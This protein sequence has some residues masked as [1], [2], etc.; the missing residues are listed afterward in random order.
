MDRFRRRSYAAIPALF[1]PL[2]SNS[3]RHASTVPPAAVEDWL[4]LWKWPCERQAFHS[5]STRATDDHPQLDFSQPVFRIRISGHFRIMG[6]QET[7][8][9][10]IDSLPPPCA[11]V[12]FLHHPP[13]SRP[14][15]GMV[16]LVPPF[17]VNIDTLRCLPDP[18][19]TSFRSSRWHRAR[20][21]QVSES[22]KTEHL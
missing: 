21:Q 13:E 10:Y 15:E 18:P 7:S 3:D 5:F 20:S 12:S 4:N 6:N 8:R 11:M 22:A 17:R 9:N 14:V 2:F 19:S 16:F 1:A